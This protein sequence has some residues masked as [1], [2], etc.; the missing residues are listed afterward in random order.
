MSAILGQTMSEIGSSPDSRPCVSLGL[1]GMPTVLNSL[2]P[3][4]AY[5]LSI[6]PAF[7]HVGFISSALLANVAKGVRCA[8]MTPLSPETFLRRCHPECEQELRAAMNAK[9]LVFMTMIGDYKKNIVRFGPEKFLRE[10]AQCGIEDGSLLV[11]DQAEQLFSLHHQE[12]ALD[13]LKA[14]QQWLERTQSTALLLFSRLTEDSALAAGHHAVVNQ[15]SGNARLDCAHA[16]A[17]LWVDFW[18]SGELTIAER[19]FA[20]DQA[21]IGDAHRRASAGSPARLQLA[22][23][24][25]PSAVKQIAGAQDANDVYYLGSALTRDSVRQSGRWTQVHSLVDMIHAVREARAATVIITASQE[26]D[27]RALAQAVHTMRMNAGPMLRI[28]IL[29]AGPAIRYRQ[30][31]LLLRLGANLVVHDVTHAARLPLL[32]ESLRSQLY[33]RAKTVSFDEAI[34]SATPP[35][36]K[37]YLPPAA[38][39]DEVRRAL[40]QAQALDLPC[41]LIVLNPSLAHDLPASLKR[42]SLSREG[43]LLTASATR[44]YVFLYGCIVTDRQSLLPRLLGLHDARAIGDLTFLT[45]EMPILAALEDIANASHFAPIPMLSPEI[46]APARP[47]PLPPLPEREGDASA[48]H[49]LVAASN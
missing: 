28:V 30:E 39:C 36:M 21:R 2:A 45:E 18:H 49:W 15:T 11:I 48:V 42:V 19:R 34:A 25:P 20:L 1:D 32:L 4:S 47:K 31:A 41:A 24:T 35:Q 5:S 13:Q 37:G 40:L 12:V 43:D 33:V 14:Y 29:N 27:W 22:S 16:A 8:L 46:D 23:E 3:G 17:E 7:S 38:F 10:L 6:R 9:Q 44:C 26:T